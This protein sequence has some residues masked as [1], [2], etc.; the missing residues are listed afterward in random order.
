MD[1]RVL[2]D[3]VTTNYMSFRREYWAVY[4]GMGMW[5]CVINCTV[6]RNGRFYIISLIQDR[7][8]GKPGEETEGRP[9]SAEALKTKAITSLRDTTDVVV[10][11]FDALL[12]SVQIHNER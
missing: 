4:A 3:S 10:K 8:L 5:E 1:N 11:Q 7:S 6:Q 2:I 9:L 12:G